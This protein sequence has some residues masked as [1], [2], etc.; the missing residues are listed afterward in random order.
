MGAQTKPSVH[1]FTRVCS[2]CS[3][4]GHYPTCIMLQ[5]QG[6]RLEPWPSNQG[7]SPELYIFIQDMDIA[8][9]LCRFEAEAFTI[10]PYNEVTDV[11][12][13]SACL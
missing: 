12:I 6:K 5:S 4:W 1:Q 2:Y 11:C 10:L 13:I 8:T 3:G 7:Q 9:P